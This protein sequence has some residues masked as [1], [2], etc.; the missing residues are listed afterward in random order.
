MCAG[1]GTFQEIVYLEIRI[2]APDKLQVQSVR[3][4]H[5]H[6]A[7]GLVPVDELLVPRQDAPAVGFDLREDIS[8]VADPNRYAAGHGIRDAEVERFPRQAFDF[9][10]LDSRGAAGD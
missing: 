1:D 5:E 10:E 9:N 6:V 3:I 2:G 7:R 4:F 8:D